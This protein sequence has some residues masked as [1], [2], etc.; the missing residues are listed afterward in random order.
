MDPTL[1]LKAKRFHGPWL[2]S[3]GEKDEGRG[4]GRGEVL[5]SKFG[6]NKE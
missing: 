2:A 4:D 5:P 3:S 6:S 1:N